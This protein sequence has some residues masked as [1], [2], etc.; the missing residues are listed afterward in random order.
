[1]VFK[2]TS[3]LAVNRQR[4]RR[5]S[6]GHGVMG[7]RRL[8]GLST[9]RPGLRTLP[10]TV[11]S[12][13]PELGHPPIHT[14]VFFTPCL[15]LGCFLCLDCPFLPLTSPHPYSP[16]PTVPCSALRP[17]GIMSQEASLHPCH[18]HTGLVPLLCAGPHGSLNLTVMSMSAS[19]A[20]QAALWKAKTRPTSR[21]SK[22]VS[23]PACP[24]CFW[25]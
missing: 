12:S 11:Y 21:L 14:T 7:P 16:D 3:Y 2:L 4:L 5:G 23:A 6:G 1:M 22:C 25:R 15:Y 24:P 19:P 10:H 18:P 20:R 9:V 17:T 8:T 13:H